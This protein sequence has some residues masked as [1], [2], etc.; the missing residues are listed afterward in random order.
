MRVQDLI[1]LQ[2]EFQQQLDTDTV[3]G[4]QVPIALPHRYHCVSQSPN[5][6]GFGKSRFFT[7]IVSLRS[8]L[9]G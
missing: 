9:A 6:T 7:N 1:A 3:P 8:V 2:A 4:V 5:L